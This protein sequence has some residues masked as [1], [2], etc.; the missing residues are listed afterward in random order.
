MDIER[1]R[2]FALTRKP[3][4]TVLHTLPPHYT[5]T[6]FIVRRTY[7]LRTDDPFDYEDLEA[8]LENA[9]FLSDG[10][11]PQIDF[12]EIH[13]SKAVPE[14]SYIKMVVASLKF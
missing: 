14:R 7:W 1:Q 4:L 10:L 11:S 2:Q 5:P 13:P 9:R 6:E 8:Q 12:M 3:H